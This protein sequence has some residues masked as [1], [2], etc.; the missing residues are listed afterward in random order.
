MSFAADVAGRFEAH[1]IG[2]TAADVTPP[3]TL[4]DRLHFDQD[5][6]ERGQH[7]ET[8]M[9]AMHDKF[10]QLAAAVPSREWRQAIGNPTRFLES[11]ARCGDL[12]ILSADEHVIDGQPDRCVNVG[13]VV[14]NAGRPV[15]FATRRAKRIFTNIAVIA[16]KDTPEARRAVANALPLIRRTTE[17]IVLTVDQDADTSSYESIDDVRSFLRR[18]GVRSRGEVIRDKREAESILDFARSAEAELVISGA[19]GH[20]RTRQRFFGG[21]TRSLLLEGSFSRMMSG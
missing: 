6:V 11:T 14:L 4:P 21:V 20:S 10:Q 17:V 8:C 12:L 1:L 15:L 7:L 9:Q 5:Y 16:W 2:T 3:L 13:D 18:H 19:Y